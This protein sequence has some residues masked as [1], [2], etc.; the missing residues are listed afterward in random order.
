MFTDQKPK[1]LLA[2]LQIYGIFFL[3]IVLFSKKHNWNDI[4]IIEVMVFSSFPAS[5]PPLLL[6]TPH[7]T[8]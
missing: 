8:E 4:I 7:Y 5:Q 1:N 2:N 6:P 3:M